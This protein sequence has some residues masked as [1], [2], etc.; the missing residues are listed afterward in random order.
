ME[1][2]KPAPT[3]RR[4]ES[5]DDR[6]QR[7]RRQVVAA[8]VAL[9]SDRGYY[10]TTVQEI[11]NRAGV[12]AGL[13][14]QYFDDKDDILLASILDVLQRYYRDIPVA[15]QDV[16]DPLVRFQTVVATYCRVVDSCR[17]ATV[18]AYRSTKSLSLPRRQA[19]MKAERDTNELIVECIRACVDAG[20]F[21][22]VDADFVTDQ[23]VLFAHG[24]AL[25]YWRLR[26]RYTLEAYIQTGLDFYQQSLLTD[27]GW[28]R[29]AALSP[30]MPGKR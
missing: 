6:I 26:D 18:L 4:A 16:Q 12:S 20:L 30:D 25:K 8:A 9:F 15:L 28:Q 23:V 29:L 14:Y 3:K 7:R 27:L 13:I 22:A 19:I 10:R 2:E 24:W 11:A 17:D 1:G 5:H 21:R